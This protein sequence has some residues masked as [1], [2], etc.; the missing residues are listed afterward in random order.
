[1]ILISTGDDTSFTDTD[2]ISNDSSEGYITSSN[3]EDEIIYIDHFEVEQIKLHESDILNFHNN[4][5]SISAKSIARK[6][7]RSNNKRLNDNSGSFWH[8]MLN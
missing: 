8:V 2:M 5:S 1:M 7:Q 6:K 4:R 3:Y